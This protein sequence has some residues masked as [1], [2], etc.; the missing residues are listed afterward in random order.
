VKKGSLKKKESNALDK[1]TIYRR[2]KERDP[3][4]KV[5]E[6]ERFPGKEPALGFSLS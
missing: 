5:G 2:K 4:R 1:K 3:A 6:R